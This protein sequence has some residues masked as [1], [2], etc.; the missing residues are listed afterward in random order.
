MIK[1]TTKLGG[2]KLLVMMLFSILAVGAFSGSL[3]AEEKQG[4]TVLIQKKDGQT[5]KGELLE[6]EQNRLLVMASGTNVGQFVDIGH[7]KAVEI[8]KTI[9]K[10]SWGGVLIGCIAGYAITKAVYQPVGG[11]FGNM[12]PF[13]LPALVGGLVGLTA[14]SAFGNRE[15]IRTVIVFEGKSPEETELA[16]DELRPQARFS[17]SK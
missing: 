16:L 9:S 7:I 10:F 6:V 15:T 1:L 8:H 3:M 12:F 17:K 13:L 5:L 4:A 11:G 2:G 14:G